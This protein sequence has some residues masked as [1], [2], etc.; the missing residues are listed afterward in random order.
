MLLAVSTD[1]SGLLLAFDLYALVD[2]RFDVV[3]EFDTGDA[4]INH[5]DT[6]RLYLFVGLLQR[7]GSELTLTA[8][9][10]LLKGVRIHDA[11]QRVAD[12]RAE[13]LA[14]CSSSPPVAR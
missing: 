9:D 14:G 8:G 3:G 2:R 7:A 10:Q 13:T 11:A 5:R 1:G 12:D 6:Q 4:H